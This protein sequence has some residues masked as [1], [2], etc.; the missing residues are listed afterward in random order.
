VGLDETHS[1]HVMSAARLKTQR[2]SRTAARQA[3]NSRK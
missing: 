2:E 3:G 1:A